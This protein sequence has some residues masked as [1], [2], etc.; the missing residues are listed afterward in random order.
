MKKIIFL[1][2]LLTIFA[3][4]S[5]SH[6]Q[7]E[8]PCKKKPY[9]YT[10]NASNL[11]PD[12]WA[13]TY[14]VDL[15]KDDD[16]WSTDWGF[17]LCGVIRKTQDKGYI[18]ATGMHHST[19][20]KGCTLVLKLNSSGDIEWQRA[21]LEHWDA[22]NHSI[23]QTH[24][25]GYI[26]ST[27]TTSYGAG[28][29][30]ILIFKLDSHGDIEWQRTY[31]GIGYEAGY[32]AIQET[33]DG[34]YVYAGSSN[35]FGGWGG[36]IFK[37][38]PSGDIEW[39]RFYEWPCSSLGSLHQTDDGGYIVIGSYY[40]NQYGRK[41]TWIVKLTS[42]GDAEWQRFYDLAQTIKD[43]RF[44]DI[45][46][47]SSD[48]K[49]TIDGGYIVHFFTTSCGAGG[50]DTLILKLRSG[51][52]IEWQ[53][54]YG[55][56][57]DE[58]RSFAVNSIEQTRDGGFVVGGITESFGAGKSD[59]WILKLTPTGDIEWQHTYGGK[60]EED[61]LSIQETSDGGY[62][63]G[64]WSASFGDDMILIL[65][66]SSDGKIGPSCG[67]VGSS[68]ASI[69]KTSVATLDTNEVPFEPDAITMSANLKP[70][71]TDSTA[72]LICG[73]LNQPPL[74]VSLKREIN[75]S[76]FRKE[77]FH[78][79]TWRPNPYNDL[80]AIAEY[81]I[82]RCDLTRDP[83]T[84]R[85]IASVP[86]NTFAYGDKYLDVNKRFNYAVTSVDSEGHESSRSQVV[87]N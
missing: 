46:L 6:A 33:S 3:L 11:G 64:G 40:S 67:I 13:K 23:Q 26:I 37:L 44:G 30:D 2:F 55:G 49:Q 50:I 59:I 5:T 77:A 83:Q 75:R 17:G 56:S 48:I 62:I 1:G 31:G 29:Y 12:Q 4:F 70:Y 54:S 18:F 60:G 76:L 63:V 66:L 87:G 71:Q 84:Y 57:E 78:T 81:R 80:F 35:T 79:I 51:G 14:R 47:G 43:P 10:Y 74:S 73:N 36:W 34:G 52:D 58:G 15:L 42:S 8:V 39:E 32:C 61:L 72:D 28:D 86:G 20:K 21:Y 82:Y 38:N 45:S 25:G 85:L 9:D 16:H 27:R 69:S 65:K 68:N 22:L 7:R 24:D 53:R 41:G 19:E